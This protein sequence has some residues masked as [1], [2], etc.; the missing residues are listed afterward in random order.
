V[1]NAFGHLYRTLFHFLLNFRLNPNPKNIFLLTSSA[2]LFAQLNFASRWIFTLANI[3]D[4]SSKVEYHFKW[5]GDWLLKIGKTDHLRFDQKKPKKKKIKVTGAKEKT[6]MISPLR[7][8]HFLFA[9]KKEKIYTKTFIFIFFSQIYFVLFRQGR[10][11]SDST[12][13][14]TCSRTTR[15]YN[16][17]IF[18]AQVFPFF[19]LANVFDFLRHYSASS[20]ILFGCAHALLACR[21]L[22][23]YILRNPCSYNNHDKTKKITTGTPRLLS[24]RLP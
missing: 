3:S 5:R 24:H 6:K 4:T 7:W 1:H 16:Q 2:H 10:T 20:N 8:H 9:C 12:L 23:V 17:Q 19:S 15:K 18:L 13:G 11:M 22:L 21:D 14:H